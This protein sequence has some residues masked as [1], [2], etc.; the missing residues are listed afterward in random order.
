[1]PLSR[2][3][4]AEVAEHL[5][6]VE[7]LQALAMAQGAGPAPVDPNRS[8][9][10]SIVTAPRLDQSACVIERAGY[11]CT[12]CGALRAISMGGNFE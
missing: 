3:G 10:A 6:L 7:A 8:M 2:P 11:T 12:T 4:P 1:M 9:G 5:G